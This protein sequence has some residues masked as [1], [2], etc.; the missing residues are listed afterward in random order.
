MHIIVLL[1]AMAI[2]YTNKGDDKIRNDDDN[3]VT[4]SVLAAATDIYDDGYNI[5]TATT[6]LEMIFGSHGL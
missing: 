2:K 6:I 1:V 4:A 5:T 3:I